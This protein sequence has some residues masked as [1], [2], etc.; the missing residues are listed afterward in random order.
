MEAE[1]AAT[2]QN[3]GLKLVELV[4]RLPEAE[5]SKLIRNARFIVLPSEGYYET[6]G[7]VLI[8]GYAR[9][10]PALVS[11]IGVLPEM[12]M[13]G[14]TGLL[15]EPG[16][17]R[18]LADKAKWLGDHPDEVTQMGRRAFE[19]YKEKFSPERAYASLMKIYQ[20]V[21]GNDLSL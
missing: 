10:I 2:V 20:K 4:G 6:F 16:D 15:F 14:E 8:E 19:I 12:V 18:D 3:K 21:L 11:R 1:I 7:M 5:L 13:D 9:G 17:P